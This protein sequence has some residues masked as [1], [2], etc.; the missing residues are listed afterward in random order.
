MS[1][2]S[3]PKTKSLKEMTAEELKARLA[4]LETGIKDKRKFIEEEKQKEIEKNPNLKKGWEEIERKKAEIKEWEARRAAAK[5]EKEEIGDEVRRKIS[6]IS[7][8]DFV[9]VTPKRYFFDPDFMKYVSGEQYMALME[10]GRLSDGEKVKATKARFAFCWEWLDGPNAR[11]YY[12]KKAKYDKAYSEWLDALKEDPDAPFPKDENGEEIKEP[13]Y[14]YDGE[15]RETFRNNIR[16][17]K[18]LVYV[19]RFMPEL[20]DHFDFVGHIRFPLIGEIRKHESFAG[21]GRHIREVKMTDFLDVIKHVEERGIGGAQSKAYFD[22]FNKAQLATLR[23]RMKKNIAG[24]ERSEVSGAGSR[25][26]Q[27]P[28]TIDLLDRTIVQG[29]RQSDEGDKRIIAKHILLALASGK[30]SPQNKDALQWLRGKKEGHNFYIIDEEFV[31]DIE[32]EEGVKIPRD[33]LNRDYPIAES[34]ASK[35]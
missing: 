14:K 4:Q 12:R 11:E 7:G 26:W 31:K 17:I 25:V 9:E 2:E 16:N 21:R 30:I 23:E 34:G 33:I 28:A 10:D 24:K 15:I 32:K 5:K 22:T 19:N 6:K 18:E 1:K 35:K 20:F 3:A 27:S 8:K 13:E 29:F